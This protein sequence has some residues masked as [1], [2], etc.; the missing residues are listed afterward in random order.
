MILRIKLLFKMKENINRK[1]LLNDFWQKLA[2][3]PIHFNFFLQL[4]KILKL[5]KITQL[6]SKIEKPCCRL[7]Y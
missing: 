6:L 3:F 1:I 5:F 2:H 4:I 7:R